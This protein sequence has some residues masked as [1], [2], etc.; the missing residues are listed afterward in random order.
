[1]LSFLKLVLFLLPLQAN[2]FPRGRCSD[3]PCSSSP[4]SV[5]WKSIDNTNGIFCFALEPKTCVQTQFSCCSKLAS[6]LHKIVF[7]VNPLCKSTR[8]TVTIDGVRKGGGI[9]LD[10]Y[11]TSSELRITS[12]QY[13]LSTVQGTT[14]CIYA[15]DPCKSLSTFCNDAGTGLCKYSIF[16]PQGHVCCPSCTLAPTVG[17]LERTLSSPPPNA[18]TV[19]ISFPDYD[20]ALLEEPSLP[21][22]PLDDPPSPSPPLPPHPSPVV[23]PQAA[24]NVPPSTCSCSCSCN[25]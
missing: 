15:S 20:I 24:C 23:Q 22:I 4:Y 1:M 18:V 25:E 6:Q 11:D 2:A 9:F 13:N 12:M 16:D 3:R 19:P 7:S 10:N 17:A 5:S 14:F 21:E 8:P